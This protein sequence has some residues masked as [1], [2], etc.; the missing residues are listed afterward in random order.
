MFTGQATTMSHGR[1]V[2][3][4]ATIPFLELIEETRQHMDEEFEVTR[5]LQTRLPLFATRG[6][7]LNWVDDMF[8]RIRDRLT[9]RIASLIIS[10]WAR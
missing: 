3:L 5:Q 2:S 1:S 8:G 10:A 7:S 9:L 6:T 4:P